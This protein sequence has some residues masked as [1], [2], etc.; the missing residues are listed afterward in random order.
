MALIEAEYRGSEEVCIK[1]FHHSR[2]E[3]EIAVILVL[4]HVAEVFIS[5]ALDGRIPPEEDDGK[6]PE[7]NTLCS[8]PSNIASYLIWYVLY[9]YPWQRST[10]AVLR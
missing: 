3:G 10:C 8:N 1:R 7:T 4:D 6:H 9:L 2:R 5:L